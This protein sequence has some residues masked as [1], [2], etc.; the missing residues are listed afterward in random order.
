MYNPYD[1]KSSTYSHYAGDPVSV[2]AGGAGDGTEVYSDAIEIAVDLPK[3]H[4]I[5]FEVPV[6][7]TLAAGE[8][9]TVEGRVQYSID[10]GSNWIDVDPDETLLTLTG[11]TGGSTERGMARVGTFT[12]RANLTHMRLVAKPTLSASGTDVVGV[13]PY[14]ALFGGLAV[15]T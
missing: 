5:C 2:T 9:V 4:S 14:V 15:S 8:T 6:K 12:T 11:A 7:A 3:N 1:I 13:G 10:G